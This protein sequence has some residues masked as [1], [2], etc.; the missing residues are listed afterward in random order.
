[1]VV[2]VVVA[3]PHQA[4]VVEVGLPKKN[5]HIHDQYNEE[6]RY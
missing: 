2:V 1:V 4:M 3:L 6:R 5:Q